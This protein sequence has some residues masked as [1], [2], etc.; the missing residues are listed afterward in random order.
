MYFVQRR[1]VSVLAICGGF[2]FGFSWL[3]GIP[4]PSFIIFVAIGGVLLTFAFVMA[5]IFSARYRADSACYHHHNCYTAA[6][7]PQAYGAVPVY[8]AS[9]VVYSP[10]GYPAAEYAPAPMPGYIYSQPSAPP[11]TTKTVV[12][13]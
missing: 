10:A 8:I 11:L 5:V 3:W 12:Y 6:P 13:Q 2:F 9:P 7:P 4:S 1:I